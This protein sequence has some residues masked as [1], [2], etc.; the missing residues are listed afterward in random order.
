MVPF[1]SRVPLRQSGHDVADFVDVHAPGTPL[2]RRNCLWVDRHLVSEPCAASSA[3]EVVTAQ[4]CCA[5]V[6]HGR[7][8][9]IDSVRPEF[10]QAV[11]GAR[12][13]GPVST[14]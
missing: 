11:R 3:A 6:M 14:V 13:D 1:G 9:N 4:R 8:W 2:L 10:V 12:S 7:D 5:V